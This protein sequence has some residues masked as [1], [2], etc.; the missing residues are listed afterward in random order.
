MCVH[1]T[2]EILHAWFEANG[3]IPTQFRT[4]H[5]FPARL[6]TGYG[7]TSDKSAGG[8][9]GTNFLTAILDI[10]KAVKGSQT[11]HP[12]P[13]MLSSSRSSRLEFNSSSTKDV[14]FAVSFLP[15][16][17]RNPIH[18]SYPKKWVITTVTCF[19]T[20]LVSASATSFSLGASSMMNDLNCTQFQATLGLSLYCLGFGVL[21][22]LT[23][24]LSEDFGRLP[25]YYVSVA[26]FLLMHVMTALAKNIQTVLVA[27]FLQG[28]FGSTGSTMVAGTVADIWNPAEI[29]LP[30]ALYTLFAFMGNGVG[31]IVAGWVEENQRLQWRWI[32]W[33][34]LIIGGV[35]FLVMILTIDET[36][37]SV[38][39]EKT[40]KKLR[41][42]SKDA[43]YYSVQSAAKLKL[44]Q[45][46]YISCTRP[47]SD[48]PHIWIGFA[49]GV[50]FCM[51]ES[52]PGVFKTLHGFNEGQIGSVYT[53]MAL[54]SLLGFLT[55]RYQERLYR[56]YVSTR[57]AQARLHLSC[58]AGFLFPISM[59]MFAWSA[60]S[61]V[62]WIVLVVALSI[63]L[64]AV[65][66]IYMTIF[67]Y[68][69]D[70]YG[71]YASSALAGQSLCRNLM[72]TIFP[73]FAERM[74]RAL[75]Y[76]WANT[77]FAI[78]GT[79]MSPIPIILFFYGPRILARSKMVG[80]L[81]RQ[82]QIFIEKQD[83][84]QP[85]KG[86]V[87]DEIVSVSGRPESA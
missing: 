75:G 47:I 14:L 37:S 3:S 9:C 7:Q 53:T 52:I 40:A 2:G 60:T 70:C 62:P 44:S 43:R 26:G 81:H 34:H 11:T 28:A 76:R 61:K 46:I 20:L 33:I 29:G 83:V 23:S 32:Q 77:I 5:T 35:Y 74:F 31:A 86:M 72:A 80:Q 38:I 1:K 17:R 13:S 39:L 67:T 41:H 63:Y 58:V 59:F 24:S 8:M 66:T 42:A 36:R 16:D 71:M 64:W 79:V 87:K 45:R 10:L 25:L 51:I 78:A 54:G 50:Y 84:E 15:G 73:L 69:A 57:G 30:M 49:W 6:P 65:S 56:K 68:L 22:L 82:S 4:D 27:R 19:F 85:S 48:L 55:N 21:P 18:F 12:D